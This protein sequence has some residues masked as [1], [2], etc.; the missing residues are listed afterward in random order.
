LI[1]KFWS[2]TKNPAINN[3]SKIAHYIIKSS[4]FFH[5]DERDGIVSALFKYMGYSFMQSFYQPAKTVQNSISPNVAG[6]DIHYAIPAGEDNAA[7]VV[8]EEV[9]NYVKTYK[10]KHPKAPLHITMY[11]QTD[12]PFGP[13]QSNMWEI[14]LFTVDAKAEKYDPAAVDENNIQELRKIVLEI[15]EVA[16]KRISELN[17]KGTLLVHENIWPEDSSMKLERATHFE[18]PWIV[19]GPQIQF[20]DVWK[21]L[22]EMEAGMRKLIQEE[23]VN[24]KEKVVQIKIEFKKQFAQ[25]DSYQGSE[26]DR[27]ANFLIS[28]YENLQKMIAMKAEIAREK[29]FLKSKL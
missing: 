15:A 18:T 14:Q 25:N 8:K 9:L 10:E 16:K 22:I 7:A 19:C 17:L 13:W 29:S 4:I 5:F 3:D 20:K 12:K 24:W 11:R 21:T 6:Y 23:G 1:S 28:G 2:C 26:L 27:A